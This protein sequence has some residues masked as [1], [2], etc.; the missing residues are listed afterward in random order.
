MISC[1]SC[2]AELKFDVESQMMK[3]SHCGESFGPY[4]YDKVDSDAEKSPT[5]DARVWVCPGCGASIECTDEE[6]ITAV[7]SYCGNNRIIFDRIRKA[8]K[9][10]GIIPFTVSKEDCKKFYRK[11]A[12]RAFLS[13]GRLKDAE[14][15]D[16]FR[17]IYMPYWSFLGKFSSSFI[18]PIVTRPY[19]SGDYIVTD[20]KIIKGNV[21][22]DLQYASHDAS[23]QFDDNIS[24]SLAPYDSMKEKKFTPGY[25]CGFYAETDSM[26]DKAY[27]EKIKY[28][29][30]TEIISNTKKNMTS[31]ARPTKPAFASRPFATRVSENFIPYGSCRTARKTR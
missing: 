30:G 22:A 19:R 4:I 27:V 12:R 26:D 15:I 8:R 1:P 29:L 10:S 6:D 20:E 28:D 9:P 11:A 24:E 18:I 13:P 14:Q 7:C 5:Y 16:S 17:G 21:S 31:K 3:C 25:L 23:K 2:G